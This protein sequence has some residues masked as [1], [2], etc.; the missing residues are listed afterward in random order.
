MEVNCV[1]ESLGPRVTRNHR[2]R[3]S[4]LQPN[5]TYQI[6]AT[7]EATDDPDGIVSVRSETIRFTTR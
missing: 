5:T 4:D 7:S 6:I 2:F 1:I 3:L